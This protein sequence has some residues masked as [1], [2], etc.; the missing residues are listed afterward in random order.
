[1]LVK[2]AD[3]TAEGEGCRFERGLETADV[4]VFG[5]EKRQALLCLSRKG[6]KKTDD[7]RQRKACDGLSSQS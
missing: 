2:A 6:K 3:R 5:S 1:M 7:Q 4:P